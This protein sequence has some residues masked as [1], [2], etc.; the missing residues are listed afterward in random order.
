MYTQQFKTPPAGYGGTA[1]SKPCGCEE[2]P[3][4]DKEI[5]L[6]PQVRPHRPSFGT[7]ELLAAAIALTVLSGGSDKCTVLLL[8]LLFILL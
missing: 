7:D 2:K 8:A 3:P 4:C 1:I 6:P 5:P